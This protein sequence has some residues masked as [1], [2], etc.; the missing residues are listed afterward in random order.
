[1]LAVPTIALVLAAAHADTYF[2]CVCY[3]RWL[4]RRGGKRLRR[5][6]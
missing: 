1:M 6:Q 4:N 2:Y 3:V 5:R